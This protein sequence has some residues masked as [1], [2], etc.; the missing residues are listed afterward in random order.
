MRVVPYIEQF[1]HRIAG[2]T[3]FNYF[4]MFGLK[5]GNGCRL[6]WAICSPFY[7][8][9]GEKAGYGARLVYSTRNFVLLALTGE[10]SWNQKKV[11]G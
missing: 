1:N 9:S 6:K 7:E 5:A 10:T 3:Q 2:D 8:Y 4:I 11:L